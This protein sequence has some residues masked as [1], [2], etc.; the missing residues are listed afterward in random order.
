MTTFIAILI[1][2]QVFLVLLMIPPI[3]RVAVVLLMLII[4][5]D[6]WSREGLHDYYLMAFK[7]REW[8]RTIKAIRQ[9]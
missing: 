1:T 2:L 3:R 8:E 5:P 9:E 7:P 6:S 4:Y